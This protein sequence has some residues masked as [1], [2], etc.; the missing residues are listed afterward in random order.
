MVLW[1]AGNSQ[2]LNDIVGIP[3]CSQN[4]GTG[5]PPPQAN[6]LG[7]ISLKSDKTII[8]LD[9]EYPNVDVISFGI[10]VVEIAPA[11]SPSENLR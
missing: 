8:T 5:Q 7:T 2:A 4:L 11:E 1:I 9:T 3:H 6:L 10:S